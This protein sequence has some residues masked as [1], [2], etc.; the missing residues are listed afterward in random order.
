MT[1]RITFILFYSDKKQ[2]FD[3]LSSIELV[4]FDQANNFLMQNWEH[5]EVNINISI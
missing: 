4:I 1:I 3:F 2:D 5:V